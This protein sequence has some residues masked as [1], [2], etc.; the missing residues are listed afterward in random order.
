[1]LG[2]NR[3]IL[4][5]I[6]LVDIGQFTLIIA[7]GNAL[8]LIVIAVDAGLALIFDGLGVIVTR[9]IEFID[10][11]IYFSVILF[12]IKWINPTICTASFTP[13]SFE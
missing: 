7:L 1:M 3:A 9:T 6:E 4:N 8:S 2:R 12:P 5:S 10:F 11:L 13:D